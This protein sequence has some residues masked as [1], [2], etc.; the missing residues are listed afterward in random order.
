[1]TRSI[2][3]ASIIA[4]TKSKKGWGHSTI[5]MAAEVAA[6]ARVKQLVLF[7]HEPAA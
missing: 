3:T 7:H 1:M 4:R 5:E 2:C 6:K